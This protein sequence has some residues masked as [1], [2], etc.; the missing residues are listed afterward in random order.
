MADYEVGYKKPPK[1]EGFDKHPERRSNGAWKK[2]ETARWKFE[3]WIKMT[4]DELTALVNNEKE[5]LSA[6]DLSTVRIILKLKAFTENIET[7]A[8]AERCFAVLERLVNQIYGQPKVQVEKTEIEPP[9]P[10]SPR[11]QK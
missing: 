9:V 1:S 6:F 2:S 7:T 11:K 5:P 4:E 3:Q 10:L 8:D